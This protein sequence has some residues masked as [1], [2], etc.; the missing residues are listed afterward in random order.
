MPHENA[1]RLYD[2][3]LY[4]N[5]ITDV[6][7]IPTGRIYIYVNMFGIRTGFLGHVQGFGFMKNR[8]HGGGG[9]NIPVYT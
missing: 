3:Y 5:N 7:D 6:Y 8:L 1:A 4:N 2:L 9:G